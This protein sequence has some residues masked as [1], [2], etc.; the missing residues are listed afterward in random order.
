MNFSE[1]KTQAQEIANKHKREM[2]RGGSHF[3]TSEAP[4]LVADKDGRL[5]DKGY[6]GWA[7]GQSGDNISNLTKKKLERAIEE[8]NE[9]LNSERGQSSNIDLESVEISL[10]GNITGYESIAA[11]KNDEFD[12]DRGTFDIVIWNAK[13]GIVCREL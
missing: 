5:E 1:M 9:F 4:L 10:Y 12:M 13:E 2:K 6:S 11:Y 3:M 8:L 7:D